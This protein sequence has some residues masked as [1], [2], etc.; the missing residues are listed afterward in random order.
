MGTP[1]KASGK[2]WTF[3]RRG[4]EGISGVDRAGGG[5]GDHPGCRP[6]LSLVDMAGE[7]GGRGGGGEVGGWLLPL[8][9][10]SLPSA[11]EIF[12]VCQD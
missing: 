10:F 9:G 12:A 1:G 3:R 5:H 7:G 8:T 2:R 11:Y 4:Q 6:R